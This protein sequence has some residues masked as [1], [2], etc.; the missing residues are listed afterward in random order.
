MY[1][2]QHFAEKDVSK[3]TEWVFDGK[4]YCV[5]CDIAPF[6]SFYTSTSLLLLIGDT[7]NK[8]HDLFLGFTFKLVSFPPQFYFFK[9]G[10]SQKSDTDET[11]RNCQDQIETELQ[12]HFI[13]ICDTWFDSANVDFFQCRCIYQVLGIGAL[14]VCLYYYRLMIDD[15]SILCLSN[16]TSFLPSEGFGISDNSGFSKWYHANISVLS[17][18]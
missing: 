6:F 9:V 17:N 10:Y 1:P 5:H 11:A 13:N 16:H 8:F 3:F 15:F 7:R 4:K 14:S 2:S 18:I 12:Y